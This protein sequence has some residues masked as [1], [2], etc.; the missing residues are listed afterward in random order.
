MPRL[1]TTSNIKPQPHLKTINNDTNT[2]CT[3]NKILERSK[4][5]E[6][7]YIK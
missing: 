2:N 6:F 5:V 4:S 1:Y 3:S 7:V